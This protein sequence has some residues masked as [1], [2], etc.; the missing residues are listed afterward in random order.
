MAQN[1]T[2][3]PARNSV[4]YSTFQNPAGLGTT[5]IL[6][7]VAGQKIRVVSAA[8]VTTLANSVKFLSNATDISAT[9]PLGANGGIVLPYNDHGWV[10]TAAGEALQI[11]LSVAT[12][13]AVH[14][15]YIIL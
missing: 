2:S 9:F 1:V 8:I 5:Q 6:A 13:T 4:I 7:G 15:Q 3:T 11:N 14:V 10:Q 12:A